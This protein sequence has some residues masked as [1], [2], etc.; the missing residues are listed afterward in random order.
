VFLIVWGFRPKAK[1][2]AVV[3]LACG[4]GHVTAHRIVRVVR[5]FTLFYIPIFPVRKRYFSV[6]AACGA[7]LRI[8]NEAAHELL[9][10]TVDGGQTAGPGEPAHAAV[11]S[12]SAPSEP[13]PAAPPAGWYP[14]PAGLVGQRYW[15]GARW[16]QSV[17]TGPA[18]G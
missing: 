2:E 9:T 15:D 5:W 18:I 12:A 17:Q 10:S 8:P 4:N 16:T 6:C 13:V 3:Q 7:Q 14:D 11:G 1:I